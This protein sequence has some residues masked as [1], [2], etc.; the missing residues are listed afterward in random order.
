MFLMNCLKFRVSKIIPFCGHKNGEYNDKSFVETTVDD[1]QNVG[2]DISLFAIKIIRYI[3]VLHKWHIQTAEVSIHVE[4]NN[5]WSD[6]YS[7][8]S[9]ISLSS[10]CNSKQQ[11][12]FFVQHK[13]SARQRRQLNFEI[14]SVQAVYRSLKEALHI[15]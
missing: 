3:L 12:W 5:L 15:C 8:I 4:L 11:V 7:T 1:Q 9:H 2:C 10:L 13:S 6:P 14:C